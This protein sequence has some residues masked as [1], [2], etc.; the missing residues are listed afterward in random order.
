M[1]PVL[2]RLLLQIC[3][4]PSAARSH[5]E[6]WL[7]AENH[8]PSWR[9]RWLMEWL[10]PQSPMLL[11]MQCPPRASSN[12][13]RLSV[14]KPLTAIENN[15]KIRMMAP[16]SKQLS[17]YSSDCALHQ[18]RDPDSSLLCLILIAPHPS[19]NLLSSACLASLNLLF[20]QST[21][22]IREFP[23][24]PLSQ[25]FQTCVSNKLFRE[26]ETDTTQTSPTTKGLAIGHEPPYSTLNYAC[27]AEW[28]WISQ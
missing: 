2:G 15:R 3:K 18:D 23:D 19:Q 5:L 6:L 12:R 9:P 11:P 27:P 4:V 24:C 26:I 25:F 13:N 20:M 17:S 14:T 22:T 21:S 7:T 1:P 8:V 10:A 16:L 28:C